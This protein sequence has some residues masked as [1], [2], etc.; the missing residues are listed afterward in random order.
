M[1]FRSICMGIGY[2]YGHRVLI[3]RK[4]WFSKRW[5]LPLHGARFG[6]CWDSLLHEAHLDKSQVLL[7]Y[8]A[9][10]NKSRVLLLREAHLD[11]SSNFSKF[12]PKKWKKFALVWDVE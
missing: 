1:L 2:L 7:L 5:D 9:H 4:A 11:K 6:K 8:E 10:L 3:L 12:S